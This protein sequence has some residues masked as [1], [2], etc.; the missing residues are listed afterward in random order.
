MCNFLLSSKQFIENARS[1]MSIGGEIGGN[2]LIYLANDDI[3]AVS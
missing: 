3:D 1:F 2:D